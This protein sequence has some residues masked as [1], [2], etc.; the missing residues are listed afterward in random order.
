MWGTQE[1]GQ[2]TLWM[3]SQASWGTGEWEASGG[4]EKEE[5]LKIKNHNTIEIMHVLI[6]RKL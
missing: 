6:R 3:V 4:R 5:K 2:L 1:V